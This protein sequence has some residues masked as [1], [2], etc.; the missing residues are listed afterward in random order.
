MVAIRKNHLK[1]RD[2]N[3]PRYFCSIIGTCLSLKEL[4]TIARKSRIA[5]EKTVSDY[6][7]HGYFVGIAKDSTCY[8]HRQ[9]Q[10]YFDKKFQSNIREFSCANSDEDLRSL[11]ETALESAD[12]A[13][14]YYALATHTETSRELQEQVFG[15]IHM[16]SHLSGASLRIDMQHLN[17]I[18]QKVK[19]Q[20]KELT[21]KNTQILE[22]NK[23]IQQLSQTISKME[24]TEANFRRLQ[25]RLAETASASEEAS[26]ESQLTAS[27][28][29]LDKEQKHSRALENEMERWKS[30]A[31][32]LETTFIEI[33][34]QRNLAFQERDHLETNLASLLN[35][36]YSSMCRLDDAGPFDKMDLCGR[37]ILYVGGR[38][39]Q[40][41]HF[42]RLVE[43][44]NGRFIHHDGGLEDGDQRLSSILSQADTVMCPLDC[45]SHDAMNK[46]KRHCEHTTK[47][48]VVMP[49][50]SL[51]AFTRGLSEINI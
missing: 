5:V 40:C 23:T 12:V 31:R 30:R 14:S 19:K 22:K 32:Q 51:S 13:G 35:P 18:E 34:Q 15:D 3:D 20:E 10:K 33:E 46:V 48:L 6:D 7:L 8:A 25:A 17:I 45:I 43:Q 21:E 29:K 41:H 16:L 2:L 24:E 39:K 49:R 27:T 47:P 11:W 44:H 9:L 28:R 42:R 26:L 4:R 38:S 1:L 50:S 37:C 36:D